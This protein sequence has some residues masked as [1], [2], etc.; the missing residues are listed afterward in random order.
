MGVF[1]PFDL[2]APTQDLRD[3]PK[4]RLRLSPNARRHLLKR[5]QRNQAANNDI[6]GR[7]R[8]SSLT[9]TEQGCSI[10]VRSN[11]RVEENSRR[12][13]RCVAPVLV[14]DARKARRIQ[15][16]VQNKTGRRLGRCS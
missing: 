5:A 10:E 14:S 1:E 8:Q 2:S 13:E 3:A 9:R 16:R 4:S 12:H 15:N 7:L 6:L 11:E